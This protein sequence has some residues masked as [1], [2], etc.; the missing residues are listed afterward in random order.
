M[1]IQDNQI[2]TIDTNINVPKQNYTTFSREIDNEYKKPSIRKNII[3]FTRGQNTWRNLYYSF[4]A[5]EKI[6]QATGVVFVGLQ[7]FYK[8]SDWINIM[9]LSASVGAVSFRGLYEFAF[10]E[11]NENAK[12][13]EQYYVEAG[14][15]DSIVPK[16]ITPISTK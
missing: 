6:L 16:L 8:N 12:E 10:K 3:Y 9:A 13:L 14:L 2:L 11:S 15:K 1:S 7:G 5:I 4:A